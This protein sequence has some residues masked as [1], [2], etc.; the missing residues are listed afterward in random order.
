MSQQPP[1][2]VPAERYQQA[3]RQIDQTASRATL[4]LTVISDSM[5]PLL[6]AGDVVVVQPQE[7]RTLQVGQ[8]IVVQRHG[9]WITHRL[10]AVDAAG[11]HTHGDNLRTRDA[12]VG[13]ADIV[14]R[15]IAVERATEHG[16]RTI[17][18][19]TASWSSAGSRIAQ[20]QR[21]QLGLLDQT[22]RFHPRWLGARTRIAIAAGLS[23]PFAGLTRFLIWLTV[24]QSKGQTW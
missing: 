1:S 23:W 11:W 9:E 21:A 19:R 16:A 18:L 12:A 6:R 8:V 24:R 3:A 15:V 7:P 13:A 5:R 10:Q 2:G 20:V 17:D 22:R 4:R 14:G